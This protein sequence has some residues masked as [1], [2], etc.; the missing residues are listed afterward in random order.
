M[1]PVALL[2]LA[3]EDPELEFPGRGGAGCAEAPILEPVPAVM[4]PRGDVPAAVGPTPGVAISVAPSGIPVTPT[5]APVP[6]PSGEV[7][8]SGTGA[9][10]PTLTWA[11]AVLQP[12]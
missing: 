11:H 2:L 9:P 6:I 1:A 7:K 4:E 8:P 3:I 10:V 12:R 5:D